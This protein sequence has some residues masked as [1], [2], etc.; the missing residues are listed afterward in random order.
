[1]GNRYCALPELGALMTPLHPTHRTITGDPHTEQGRANR[2]TFV[3]ASEIP[4]LLGLSAYEGAWTV[5]RRKLGMLDSTP[6]TYH[7]ERGH[8]LE[9][10]IL[11][12]GCPDAVG[13]LPTILHPEHDCIGAN[14]DGAI[15]D[16]DGRIRTVVECKAWQWQDREGCDLME[17][18]PSAL[19]VGKHR[20]AWLQIQY[21]MLV[22]GAHEALL[23]A[24]CGG[25]IARVGVSACVGTQAVM[26]DEVVGFWAACIIGGQEPPV[27]ALDLPA[28]G[29]LPRREKAS[30]ESDDPA[31]V[32]CVRQHVALGAE[33][34]DLDRQRD[35]LAARIRLAMG[36]A[37]SLILPG[38]RADR[39]SNGRLTT[40]ET[41]R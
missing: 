31:L 3:G 12:Y 7:T 13:G 37:Q 26:L 6:A 9:P 16:A 19:P 25:S 21:Q 18:D 34:R 29:Q 36:E 41:K 33:V 2:R 20:S 32:E 14:L 38:W 40:K 11:R 30:I 15:L 35:D 5:W 22:T 1:M 17:I 27:S 24:D 8:A 4:A 28:L 10:L 39:S 23:L